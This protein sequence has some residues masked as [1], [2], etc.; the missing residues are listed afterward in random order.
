MQLLT[1]HNV[2]LQ[3]LY[4]GLIDAMCPSLLERRCSRNIGS[5]CRDKEMASPIE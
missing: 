5:T 1:R 4:L 3:S 2:H